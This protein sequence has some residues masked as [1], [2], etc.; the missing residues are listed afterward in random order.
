MVERERIRD[1]IVKGRGTDNPEEQK[2]SASSTWLR[3]KR[4]K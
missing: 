1:R 4:I 2:S 3:I